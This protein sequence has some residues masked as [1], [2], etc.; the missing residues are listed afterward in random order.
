MMS[1]LIMLNLFG[2]CL[3]LIAGMPEP[4][5]KEIAIA[6]QESTKEIQMMEIY[7]KVNEESEEITVTEGIGQAIGP[8]C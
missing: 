8:Y 5:Q 2:L 7:S 1:T 4:S 6:L 3:I